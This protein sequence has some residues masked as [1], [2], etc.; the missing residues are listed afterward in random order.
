MLFYRMGSWF[1]TPSTYNA[2]TQ[3]YTFTS[4]AGANIYG[5]FFGTITEAVGT[6]GTSA[7]AGTTTGN[8][9]DVLVADDTNSPPYA[10]IFSLIIVLFVGAIFVGFGRHFNKSNAAQIS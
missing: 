5:V 4:A 9:E 7:F 1:L 2:A 6:Q 3:T 10:A 8:V